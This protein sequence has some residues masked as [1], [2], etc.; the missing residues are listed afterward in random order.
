MNVLPAVVV[1]GVS[2]ARSSGAGRGSLFASAF[3]AGGEAGA[4]ADSVAAGGGDDFTFACFEAQ[5]KTRAQAKARA[6]AM[7]R[8]ERMARKLPRSAREV[9]VRS[10]RRSS[11]RGRYED[12]PSRARS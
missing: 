6:A 4:F 9:D 10:S 2:A 12:I 1:F 3:A 8:W 7:N 11:K 5:A